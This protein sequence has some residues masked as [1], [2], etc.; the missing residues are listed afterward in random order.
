MSRILLDIAYKKYYVSAGNAAK[1]LALSQEWQPR[2]SIISGTPFTLTIEEDN[3]AVI[4]E[5]LV[6]RRLTDDELSSEIEKLEPP[7]E[8]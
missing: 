6:P 5:P 1:L 8:F 4:P 2:G 3:L 7:V